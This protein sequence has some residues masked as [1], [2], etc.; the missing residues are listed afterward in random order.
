MQFYKKFY[1][2]SKKRRGN[3]GNSKPQK[4]KKTDCF[5]ND[6]IFPIEEIFSRLPNLSEDIF[7]RLDNRSLVSCREVS[8]TWQEYVDSQ[9]VYWI[10]QI[11]KCNPPQSKFH[12]EWNSGM[13]NS[14]G[15]NSN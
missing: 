6:Q 5:E 11:L 8:K 12:G 15:E 3:K 13:E 1:K 4:K 2:M 10:R 7:G 14:F 9:R